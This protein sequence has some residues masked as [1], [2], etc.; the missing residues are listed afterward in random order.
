VDSLRLGLV[1]LLQFGFGLGA[2]AWVC[3]GAAVDLVKRDG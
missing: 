1:F 3:L 2:F